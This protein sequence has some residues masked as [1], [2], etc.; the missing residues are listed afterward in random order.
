M[1]NAQ[2][3]R[4]IEYINTAATDNGVRISEVSFGEDITTGI[5]EK[6]P[7]VRFSIIGDLGIARSNILSRVVNTITK[8]VGFPHTSTISTIGNQITIFLKTMFDYSPHI[9]SIY[10]TNI[11]FG[12]GW[13]TCGFGQ[14]AVKYDE[15]T[16]RI[17]C[18]N[19]CMGR[20][21]VR[22]MLHAYAD[23]LADVMYL[24][25]DDDGKD[26]PLAQLPD[27]NADDDELQS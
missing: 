8:T 22:K 12:W 24:D 18:M 1:R 5:T 26:M 10:S 3:K 4:L 19:E 6:Q 9:N 23:Y 7:F 13:Y 14:L 21:S 2:A 16:N 27:L 11:Y 25:D 20:K 15:D 17:T